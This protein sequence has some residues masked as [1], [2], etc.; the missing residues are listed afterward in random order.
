MGKRGPQP[1][2][3]IKQNLSLGESIDQCWSEEALE[4]GLKKSALARIA[5]N[6][7]FADPEVIVVPTCLPGEP[8][9]RSTIQISPQQLE[10]IEAR[11]ALLQISNTMVSNIAVASRYVT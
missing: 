1:Q 4:T 3:I 2:W 9:V 6:E 7:Y 10:L 5:I 8:M 11:A